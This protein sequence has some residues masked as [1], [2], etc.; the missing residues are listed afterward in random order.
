MPSEPVVTCH[1]EVHVWCALLSK[2]YNPDLISLLV[3]DEII[4]AG[5]FHL[6][7]DRENFI[8][9][10][11]VLRMLLG[12]YL[13]TD[14]RALRFCY[15]AYGKPALASEFCSSDLRFNISHSNDIAV[16]AISTGRDLGIDIE[17]MRPLPDQ[18]SIAEQFFSPKEVADLHSLPLHL[19]ETAFYTCWT[20]KEAYIKAMGK[21]LSID[22]DEFDVELRPG[23]PASLLSVKNDPGEA[24]RWSLQEL[25]PADGYVGALGVEGHDWKLKCW[26]WQDGYHAS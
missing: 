11:G 10:R 20:R 22:L 9:A 7:R 1:S 25:I 19:Q 24:A 26:Q 3:D 15:N 23:L 16:Y 6:S 13:N 18:D 2:A 8:A 12:R 17:Y 4:R 5:K 14:P 21:G